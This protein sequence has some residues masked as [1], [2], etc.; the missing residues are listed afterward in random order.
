MFAV[1]FALFL[2]QS[3]ARGVAVAGVVQ[4]QTGAIL[5][6][7]QITLVAT[8]STAPV[9]STISDTAGAF[10]VDRVPPASYD[11]RA[12]FPGFKTK[13][14]TVRVTTRAPSATTIVMEI[15]GVTQEVSVSGGGGA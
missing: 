13:T 4:D 8:G 15:E 9:Q 1:F 5:P 11:I 7:A 10:R 6:G 12:E 14:V 3:A 2:A